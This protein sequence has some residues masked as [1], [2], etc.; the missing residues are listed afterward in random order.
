MR[1]IAIF[2]QKGGVAKT[3]TT[4]NLG[5]A[6]AAKN[7]KVLIIDI[8]PQSNGST[9]LG[10]S[11]SELLKMATAY[12]CMQNEIPIK[13]VIVSTKYNNIYLVPSNKKTANSEQTLTS[14]VGREK[15]LKYSIDMC[16]D[17][18]DFD[19]I[20]IDF[21]PSLGI[22]TING[23]VAANE[24][25]IP[26]ECEGP[27]ALD[28]INDLLNTIHLVKVKAELNPELEIKGALLTKYMPTNL[29]KEIYSEL[30]NYFG[31][32]VF[33]NVIRK[34]VAVGNAKKEHVPVIY[35]DS[36]CTSSEDYLAFAEEVMGSEA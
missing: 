12:D 32:R 15:L 14:V 34:C 8:D 20:L 3:T 27:D 26:V 16:K 29:A 10:F 1:I 13:D 36:K 33:E 4:I 11:K 18:L 7:K 6:L 24:I 30:K 28:G 21:P 19:Y 25:I 23:L 9:G 17:E 5:A 35:F 31:D 22:M 2:N